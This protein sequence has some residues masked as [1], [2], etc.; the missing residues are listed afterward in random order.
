MVGVGW[1]GR[2]IGDR[3]LENRGVFLEN[4]CNGCILF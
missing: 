3:N 4:Y 1:R 2:R